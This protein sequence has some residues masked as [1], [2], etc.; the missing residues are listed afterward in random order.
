MKKLIAYILAILATAGVTG[1]ACYVHKDDITRILHLDN[2]EEIKQEINQG[3]DE[4][5]NQNQLPQKEKV[6]VLYNVNGEVTDITVADKDM[7]IVL[8]V[9]D[10]TETQVFKGWQIKGQED[11]FTDK[12]QVTQNTEFVAVFVDKYNVQFMVDG[13]LVSQQYLADNEKLSVP[14]IPTKSGYKFVGWSTDG[15]NVV[16]DIDT[17]EV[18][19]DI[20]YLAVFEELP[21]DWEVKTMSVTADPS[22]V[23]TD[24]TDT[25]YSDGSKNYIF[26]KDTQDWE[27]VTFNGFTSIYGLQV[28]SAGET[29]YYSMSS[30]QY[31]LDKETRTWTAVTWENKPS[32][33]NGQNIWSDGTNYYFSNGKNQYILDIENRTSTAIT[34]NGL[35]S[36]NADNVW[37]D[38]ENIYYISGGVFVL[39]KETRTWSQVTFN[40]DVKVLQGG[41][42][43]S[44]GENFYY[45]NI[46]SQYVYDKETKT[47]STKEWVGL[48]NFSGKDIWTDGTNT[49]YTKNKVT[50]IKNTVSE[51]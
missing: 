3:Q 17:L 27:S 44:D 13:E 32:M 35:T 18:T 28:W 11:L 9:L 19:G 51:S 21:K 37:S 14:E 50:Y 39:D 33:F 38:G 23:W 24:G 8:L 42:I 15:V 30:S 48:S 10:N 34:W 4:N 2:K 20:T 36:L 16:E 43:W 46:D 40:G 12:Y 41:C 26:N 22:Y 1:T 45:S 31:V 29:I 5:Q 7:E 25:Y 49:Y 6:A 47:W